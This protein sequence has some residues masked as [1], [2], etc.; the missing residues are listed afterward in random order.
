MSQDSLESGPQ[1]EQAAKVLAATT[2]LIDR[3]LSA[4]RARSS[5]GGQIS[6]ARLDEQQLASYE[7]SVSWAECT[8]ARF[9]LD[10][11]PDL[12][13]GVLECGGREHGRSE[14]GAGF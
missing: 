14:R 13:I 6:A 3:V 5:E 4:L 2:Q 9:L 10:G 7:V 1:L 12:R 8:A 11:S